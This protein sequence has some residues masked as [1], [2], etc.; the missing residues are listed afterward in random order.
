MRPE[1]AHAPRKLPYLSDID[2]EHRNNYENDEVAQGSDV[3]HRPMGIAL[4]IIMLIEMTC[5]KL[6]LSQ[7]GPMNI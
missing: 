6:V 2:L 7:W 5:I 3:S 4:H 1:Q